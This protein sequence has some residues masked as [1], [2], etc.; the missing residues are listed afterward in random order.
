M[1]KGIF[2]INLKKLREKIG[3]KCSCTQDKCLCQNFINTGICVC[4]IFKSKE[5]V[6]DERLAWGQGNTQD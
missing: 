2:E 4:G 6:E 3:N 1:D 5:E